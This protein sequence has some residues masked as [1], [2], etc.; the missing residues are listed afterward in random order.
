MR[1][2][3]FAIKPFL[4]PKF[5]QLSEAVGRLQPN[6]RFFGTARSLATPATNDLSSVPP[7]AIVQQMISSFPIPLYQAWERSC[8][9]V[10]KVRVW[11]S[12]N[13]N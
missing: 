13:K 1:F 10:V 11:A 5:S 3:N 12:T 2:S 8:C 9:A 4:L 7:Y 6:L